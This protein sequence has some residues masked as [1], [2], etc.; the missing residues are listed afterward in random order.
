MFEHKTGI[1]IMNSERRRNPRI[2]DPLPI[3]VRKN[4]KE[5]KPFQFNSVA[6]DVSAS[7]ICAI[8]PQR[9]QPGDK[10][11]LHIT[12]SLAGSNSV[13]APAASASAVVL[14]TKE[15]PDGT[16]VFAASFLLHH[17]R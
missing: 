1:F 12:F 11:N 14:R 6:K 3:I 9:L 10:I 5:S 4:N 16:C 7:G 13:P 8:A 17:F 15:R 2:S